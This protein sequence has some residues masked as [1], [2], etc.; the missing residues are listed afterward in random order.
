MCRENK[1]CMHPARGAVAVTSSL[2]KKEPAGAAGTG[3]K[4]Q[5]HPSHPAPKGDGT[6]K[7]LRALGVRAERGTRGARVHGMH[8]PRAPASGSRRAGRGIW[9]RCGPP[10]GPPRLRPAEPPG[11]AHPLPSLQWARCGQAGRQACRQACGGEGPARGQMMDA[12]RA[13]AHS[14]ASKCGCGSPGWLLVPRTLP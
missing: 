2:H 6:R 11:Q 7:P 1:K 8:P 13:E 4:I 10:T 12:R 14:Q 9:C 3:E 5:C